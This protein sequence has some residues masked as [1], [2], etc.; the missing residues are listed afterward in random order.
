MTRV[1]N[2]TG[3]RKTYKIL[4]DYIFQLDPTLAALLAHDLILTKKGIAA[5][6]KHG[7]RQMIE[8]H[9]A[10]LNAEFTKARL[11]RGFVT[12]ETFRDSIN[13]GLEL[14]KESQDITTDGALPKTDYRHPRWVRV[15]TLKSTAE[16]L[17]STT[18]AKYKQSD[19]LS[20]VLA[21]SAQDKVLHIDKHIPNLLAFPP[22]CNLSKNPAYLESK[23]IFQD[24][25]S[26]FPA[27]LLEINSLDGNIIDGCA[28]PGNKTTHLAAYVASFENPSCS[29]QRIFAFERDQSR[30]NVLKKMVTIAGANDLVKIWSSTDFLSTQTANGEFQ[31]VTAILLDPS[32]SGSGIVGRDDEP[33]LILP[34]RDVAALDRSRSKSKS[35]K[36]KRDIQ[37]VQEPVKGLSMVENEKVLEDEALAERLATL[38]AFQSKILDHAMRFPSARKIVYSTCSIHA[39]ENEEVVMKALISD[40]AKQQK[41]R[42]LLRAEQ[43]PGLRDWGTRGDKDS[44]RSFLL[45]H[46]HVFAQLKG[47]PT[48][49]FESNGLSAGIA[50]EVSESCIRCEKSTGEGTMGFFVAGFVRG[51]EGVAED[52]VERVFDLHDVSEIEDVDEDEVANVWDTSFRAHSKMN[53]SGKADEPS[54]AKKEV[55]WNGFS[56]DEPPYDVAP[57]HVKS[58]AL[59]SPVKQKSRVKKAKLKAVEVTGSWCR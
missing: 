3:C 25:A 30:S 40:I 2:K 20:E 42:L 29:Q 53:G 18:F 19:K 22:S 58:H 38:S 15:N 44:C 34:S 59:A 35:K 11:R 43:V 27:H 39:A 12:L 50:D 23:I 6:A 46:S 21:A 1:L 57:V 16:E 49:T 41:W 51:E 9:K 56:D 31:N 17:L 52:A 7:L 37:S 5:P 33:Q 47:I 14:S 45:Q 4:A 10:R 28:A 32:C 54:Q 48:E 24:K 26:C 36:R 8:R 13:A 55:E